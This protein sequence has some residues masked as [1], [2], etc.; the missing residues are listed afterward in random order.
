MLAEWD[1]SNADVIRMCLTDP[2]VI[3]DTN[4][5]CQTGGVIRWVCSFPGIEG[6]RYIVQMDVRAKQTPLADDQ[7]GNRRIQDMTIPVDEARASDMHVESV[8]NVDW[9]LDVGAMVSR[10]EILC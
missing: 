10:V 8:I 1:G 7:G 9:S 6:V 2:A 4:I 3:A 5:A